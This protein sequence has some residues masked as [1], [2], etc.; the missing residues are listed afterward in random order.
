MRRAAVLRT[1]HPGGIRSGRRDLWG[2]LVVP[3]EARGFVAFAHGS[4]SSSLSPRN[5]A[6][7]E[8]LNERGLATLLFDLLHPRDIRPCGDR[9]RRRNSDRATVSAALRA[10]RQRRPKKLVLAVPVASARALDELQGDAD[11]LVCLEA[12]DAFPAIGLFYADFRQVADRDVVRLLDQFAPV[13]ED[14][15]RVSANVATR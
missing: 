13:G 8:A 6:V 12:H 9:H 5:A 14:Q 15:P 3:T 1:K 11:E 2:T 10:V 7:A 4:G